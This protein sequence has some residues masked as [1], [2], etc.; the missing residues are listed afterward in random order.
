MKEKRP[1]GRPPEY[2]KDYHPEQLIN[3]M[4]QGLCI[5]QICRAWRISRETFYLWKKDPRKPEF[6]DALQ[7]GKAAL[8][9]SYVD[10][11]QDLARG[12]IK[13]SAAA[14]IFMAKNVINWSEKF[15]LHESDDVEF[16]TEPN[17]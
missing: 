8:E 1:M 11:F 15:E 7:I 14:A 2:D 3:L 12:N 16:E 6:L 17:E 4:N 5:A 13:G 9:A 10:L